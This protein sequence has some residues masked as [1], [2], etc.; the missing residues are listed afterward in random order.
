[1]VSSRSIR[2]AGPGRTGIYAG[3]EEMNRF[4]ARLRREYGEFS[5]LFGIAPCAVLGMLSDAGLPV[6]CEGDVTGV[7]TMKLLQ[8]LAGGGVPF[9]VDL[10]RCDAADNTGVV[11]HCG[12]AP[13]SL[14]RAF[15]DT[16]YRL[17]MRVDGGDKK[18]LTNDFAL[19][20][21]RVTV[22]KLDTDVDGTMR[23][24]VATGTA[25]DTEPFIR[26]N[27]LR[28]KF[29]DPVPSL[30]DLIMQKGFEHH[31]A[32]IHADVK[33]ELLQFCEWTKI[34]PVMAGK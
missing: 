17:H 3:V 7:V 34:E 18:G 14:C 27:P 6:S 19:K 15:S 30:V 33:A 11:W 9:F 24:L 4:P 21:G 26:G 1:M 23:M 20:P 25:L 12:A 16:Q 2:A 31:Y 28:I 32:V 22:A 8:L 10:I 13:A 5:D 29:D